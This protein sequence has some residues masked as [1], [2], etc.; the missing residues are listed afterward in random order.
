MSAL[1]FRSENEWLLTCGSWT[2]LCTITSSCCTKRR[3]ETKALQK[4]NQLLLKYYLF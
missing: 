4:C 2:H 1:N 3:S